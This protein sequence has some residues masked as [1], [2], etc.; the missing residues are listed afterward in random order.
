MIVRHHLGPSSTHD[1][2]TVAHGVSGHILVELGT[3]HSVV[4]VHSDHLSPN[5]LQAGLDSGM[6]GHAATVL[7]LVDVHAALAHVEATV[8]FPLAA[9]DLKHGTQGKYSL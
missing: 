3:D 2:H 7:G 9:L 4:A 6:L 8:L 1:S 5:G